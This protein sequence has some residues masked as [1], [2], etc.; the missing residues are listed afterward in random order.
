MKKIINAVM[1]SMA[2]LVPQTNDLAFAKPIQDSEQLRVDDMLMLF[3]TPNIYEAIGDYYYP[4]ILKVKPEIEPWHISVIDTHRVNG[5][6]G[7]VFSITV[8]VEP[9]LGH[10]VP[11]GKDHLTFRV[12]VGPSVRL[13]NHNHIASYGLP[14]ELQEWAVR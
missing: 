13:I 6:R 1:L 4:N 2:I 11:V 10:H 14:S 5:F 7:F 9:S 8:E 12:S 3:M